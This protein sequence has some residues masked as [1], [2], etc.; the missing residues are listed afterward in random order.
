MLLF[1]HSKAIRLVFVIASV[2]YFFAMFF[3]I[4]LEGEEDSGKVGASPNSSSSSEYNRKKG[5]EKF[6]TEKAEALWKAVETV[7]P[8]A[9]ERA[10]A[11]GAISIVG[12]PLTHRR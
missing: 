8:D 2:M 5:Y 12:S 11:E 3:K 7:I 10:D 4:I 9:R 1:N 6:K